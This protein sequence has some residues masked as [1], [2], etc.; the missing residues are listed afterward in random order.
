MEVVRFLRSRREFINVPVLVFTRHDTI[1]STRNIDEYELAGSTTNMEVVK[2]FI[3]GLRG[4]RNHGDWVGY[5][6]VDLN[7]SDADPG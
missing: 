6:G 7:D 3:D 1:I 2:R 5:D 4:V